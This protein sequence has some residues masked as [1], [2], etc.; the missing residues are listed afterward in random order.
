M[1]EWPTEMTDAARE[2]NAHLSN[3]EMVKDIRDTEQEVAGLRQCQKGYE[4]LSRNHLDLNER[5]MYALRDSAAQSSIVERQN[6]IAFLR[7]LLADRGFDVAS[8]DRPM[9][10]A[11]NEAAA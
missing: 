9:G 3:E 8:L 11:G 5:R 1:K 6:F 10:A 7:M 4:I 2:K